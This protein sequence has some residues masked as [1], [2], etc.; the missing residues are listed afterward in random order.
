LLWFAVIRPRIWDGAWR[1]HS[2]VAEAAIQHNDPVV[3]KKEL[4]AALTDAER[5]GRCDVRCGITLKRLGELHIACAEFGDAE[6]ALRR[7]LPIL[8]ASY[9]AKH[10]DVAAVMHS[11]AVV[12]DEQK[13]FEEA[14]QYHKES[15]AIREQILGPTHP[16]V[17]VSLSD[18]GAH[19]SD[20]G[21]HESEEEALAVR[22]LEIRR[23][24]LGEHDAAYGQSL[25]NLADLRIR[26]GRLTDADDLLSRSLPIADATCGH[27]SLTVALCLGA[28]AN[29]HVSRGT[30]YWA[31]AEEE[32]KQ[33][34][35]LLER[36]YGPQNPLC[37]LG[38]KPYLR[39]LEATG[40][41]AEARIVEGRLAEMKEAF[42]A[43]GGANALG[44]W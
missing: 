17:A 32:A 15:L 42:I 10:P 40:R 9:G 21:G 16:D 2:D 37:R 33:C 18:L 12:L 24:A 20:M 35:T 23:S 6:V 11:L 39:V 30:R 41:R 4:L 5:L 34:T 19:Y 29:V 14:E 28:L 27:E 22:A 44:E 25:Y 3:A 36:I 13:T 7:S 31:Q 8:S 43:Q 1:L 26:Q 38:L